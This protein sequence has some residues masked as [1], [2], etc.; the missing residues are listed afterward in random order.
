MAKEVVWRVPAL[1]D[2]DEIS[3]YIAADDEDAAERFENQVWQASDSLQTFAERGRRVP[4]LQH[5]DYR[6]L[7][8]GNYRLLYRVYPD[9]VEIAALLHGIREFRSAWGSREE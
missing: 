9:R 2:L 6:E 7:L 4:E 8:L 1:H 5:P 3:R